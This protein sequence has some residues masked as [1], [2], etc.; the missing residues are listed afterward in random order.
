MFAARPFRGP[1]RK[2]SIG[3]PAT[4]IVRETNLAVFSEIGIRVAKR[5]FSNARGGVHPWTRSERSIG[6]PATDRLLFLHKIPAAQR[7]QLD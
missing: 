7:H 3:H 6:H 4:T 2:Q 1:V 5:H